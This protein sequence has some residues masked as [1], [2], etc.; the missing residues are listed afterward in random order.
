MPPEAFDVL[1]LGVSMPN[2]GVDGGV[3]VVR[4]GHEVLEEDLLLIGVADDRFYKFL[5][6]Y[7]KLQRRFAE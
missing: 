2:P 5:P 6:I 7:G 1:D 4:D 3:R